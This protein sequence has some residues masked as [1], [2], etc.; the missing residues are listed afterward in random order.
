MVRAVIYMRV[1]GPRQ[2]NP[3]K[4]SLSEQE[5][6]CRQHSEGKGYSVVGIYSDVGTGA[7]KKRPGF[8]QMLKDA[9][10]GKFDVIVAWKADRLA[11]GIYPSAV[12]M[13][14]LENTTIVIETV[15]EPFDRVTFE[16]RAV[17]GRIELENIVQRTQLGREA[18]IRGGNH[19]PYPYFGYDY[20][21]ATKRW[22]INEFE[23]EWVR[24]SFDW[25][26]KGVSTSEIA[27]RLNNAGVPQKQRGRLG[28][29]AQAVS[30]LVNREC[31]T[32]IAYYNKRKANSSKMKAK[33]QWIPMSVPPII[34]RETWEAAQAR[35][36]SNK[37]FSPRNT[38]TIYLTQNVL[39]CKECGYQFKISS[40]K[41]T[42]PRL[43]CKGMALYPH[44][45]YCR[46]P[47][48][49]LQQPMSER[50]WAT[51]A[52]VVGS[53]EGLQVAIRDKAESL[54]GKKEVIKRDLDK[55][56]AK[57]VGLKLEKDRVITAFRK[58]YYGE[59][60]LSLQLKAIEAEDEQ[61]GAEED[62]LL[63]DLRLQRDAEDVYQQAKRLIPMMKERLN[64]GLTMAEKKEIIELL[65]RRALL[66]RNNTLTIE[67]R[68]PSPAS[69]FGKPML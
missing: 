57:R 23:A 42:K 3:E 26:M 45:F 24:Q 1:S 50:L 7:T 16:L 39:I 13:E 2:A 14:A 27:T 10:A 18:R 49:L 32:G 46:N 17:V 67:F 64:T 56:A 33:D 25:Y 19:H 11:R 41:R 68:V 61:Y 63:A 59:R 20:Y 69:C 55:I 5:R 21:R 58:R 53:E 34:T 31:Y 40:T 54:A 66:D 38:Q 44:L 37:R 8:Q 51:V 9:Q 60:E 6:L 29:T 28:W 22:A 62:R 12:L 4:V 65:V 35:R 52:A 30:R 47:K 48:S 36:Q 43:V 15:A